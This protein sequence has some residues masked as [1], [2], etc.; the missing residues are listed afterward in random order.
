MKNLNTFLLAVIAIS[1]SSIALRPLVKELQLK[2]R[3]SYCQGLMT[4]LQEA[5]D[6][7]FNATRDAK[8]PVIGPYLRRCGMF[9]TSDIRRGDIPTSWRKEP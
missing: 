4:Q 9:N 5:N 8:H 1:L 2:Q 3:L 6:T 7:G